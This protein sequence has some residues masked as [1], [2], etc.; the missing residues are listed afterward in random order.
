[1]V[2]LRAPRL[3]GSI[4]DLALPRGDALAP[5]CAWVAGVLPS[6]TAGGCSSAATAVAAAV[7]ARTPARACEA[8]SV[9]VT[10][11]RLLFVCLFVRLASN[12]ADAR[13]AAGAAAA[14]AAAMAV[15]ALAVAVT[16]SFRSDHSPIAMESDRRIGSAS[17]IEACK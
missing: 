16:P 14:A 10:V 6:I 5:H 3:A 8:G 4:A 2:R 11:P 15:A 9:R 12:A 17:R 13:A 7:A 1:M